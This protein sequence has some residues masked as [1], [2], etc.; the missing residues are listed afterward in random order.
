MGAHLERHRKGSVMTDIFKSAEA[1]AR[2]VLELQ[3]LT[4]R[5]DGLF[6]KPGLIATILRD[7]PV[8]PFHHNG[9]RQPERDCFQIR[10]ERT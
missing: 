5:A 2:A 7:E 8:H 4:E 3:G 10:Y 9:E 1:N 6:E